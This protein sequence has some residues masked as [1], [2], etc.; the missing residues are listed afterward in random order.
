MRQD[1]L[2]NEIYYNIWNNF[3]SNENYIDYF[4][5]NKDNWIEKLNN[6]KKYI[7]INKKLPSITDKTSDEIKTLGLF[8]AT[9]IQTS[10]KRE[11]IMKNDDIYNMWLDFLNDPKYI[12][13]STVAIGIYSKAAGFSSDEILNLQNIYSKYLSD[14]G[15]VP[16]DETY[17]YLPKRNVY[18]NNLGYRFFN[19]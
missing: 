14:Y 13:Y 2:C 16:F 7:D 5:S 11:R 12:D 8:I 1:N 3:I 6:I 19:Q 17:T 15:N 9:Q 18:N 4:L 10:K